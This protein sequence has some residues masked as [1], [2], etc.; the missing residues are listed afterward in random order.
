MAFPPSLREAC[1][2]LD[3]CRRAVATLLDC[4]RGK[5]YK[6]CNVHSKVQPCGRPTQWSAGP[7]PFR[8]RTLFLISRLVLCPDTQEYLV[9]IDIV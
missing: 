5:L 7:R 1:Y 9:A 2:P 4:M 8:L 3:S 6:H